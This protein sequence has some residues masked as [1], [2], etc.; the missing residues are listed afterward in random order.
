MDLD[1][2]ARLA[3]D[4]I[5]AQEAERDVTH[6]IATLREPGTAW[7]RHP[8]EA[9][10][11]GTFT[12]AVTLTFAIALIDSASAQI[13]P[14]LSI[15]YVHHTPVIEDFIRAQN[16][17]AAHTAGM[18]RIDRFVQRAP[19]D[20]APV[21]EITRAYIGHDDDNVYAAFICF[22]TTPSLVRGQPMP[23]DFRLDDD[24]VALQLDTSGNRRHAYTFQVSAAGI[25]R[26]GIW[27]EGSGT[28]GTW[29]FSFDAAWSAESHR[30]AKGYVV[31]MTVPFS[32][33]RLT[34]SAGQ[35][36]SAFFFREIPRKGE[37]AFWPEY[38]TRLA[39]RLAQAAS[40][41]LRL[42]SDD[43]PYVR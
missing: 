42:R 22:D 1:G 27:T 19:V 26:D 13:S 5:Q 39:G 29:D 28:S 34:D 14:R 11:V 37:L 32:S 41:S 43:A 24:N 12:P 18:A 25:Q 23:R 8:E 20:G 30:T 35:T 15:P 38:S 33:L 31:L 21:S 6:R 2:S 4:H 9:S 3:P 17:P 36:W 10:H 7:S 16:D 40:V